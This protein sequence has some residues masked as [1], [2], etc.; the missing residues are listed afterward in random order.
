MNIVLIT[1][2]KRMELSVQSHSSMMANSLDWNKHHLTMVIDS[3]GHAEYDKLVSRY[4]TTIINTKPQGA[5][6]SRNIGAS[7]IPKYRRQEHVCFLDDDIY[8]CRGWDEKIEAAL[9]VFIGNCA[10]SGHAHPFNLPGP[11]YS[12]SD[13]IVGYVESTSVLSSVNIACSWQMWDDVGYFVEPGGPGGSEDVDWCRR[14]TEKRYGLAVTVPQCIIHTGL[15]SSS[16]KDIVGREL[17]ENWNR[18]LMKL[19]GLKGVI[20]Q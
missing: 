5:S 3:D 19:Y 12:I 4:A 11:T 14:A 15:T 8:C 1:T 17:V 2:G 13:S 16:G 20:F 18:E 6:A 7:S 9:D 10:I